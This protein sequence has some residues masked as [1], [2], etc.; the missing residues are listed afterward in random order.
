VGLRNVKLLIACGVL[1]M[2]PLYRLE[3]IDLVR[4]NLGGMTFGSIFSLVLRLHVVPWVFIVVIQ[5]PD[6]SVSQAAL[7]LMHW[8]AG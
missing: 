7:I 3:P 8:L 1:E 6:V 4:R 2:L 5:G